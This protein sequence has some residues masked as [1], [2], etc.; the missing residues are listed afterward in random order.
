MMIIARSTQ[1][2]TRQIHVL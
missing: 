1:K 2:T